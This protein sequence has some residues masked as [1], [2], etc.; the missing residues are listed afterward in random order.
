MT[1]PLIGDA[2][3]RKSARRSKIYLRIVH[4]EVQI[5]VHITTRL[6]MTIRKQYKQYDA[7]IL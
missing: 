4:F 1:S 3:T 7:L 6:S 2:T 5:T